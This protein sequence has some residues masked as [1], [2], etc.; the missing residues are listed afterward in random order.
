M[1]GASTRS[2][3]AFFA[4]LRGRVPI[5]EHEL[6][7]VGGYGR[8]R[9]EVSG[10]RGG[11]A[12]AGRDLRVPAHRRRS[13]SSGF[14]NS[15]SESSSANVSFSLP[16]SS[17]RR[18]WFPHVSPDAIDLRAFVGHAITP[19]LDLM[20][21]VQL[22]RYFFSMNPQ[23]DDLRVAGGAV[24]QYLSG[25]AAIAWRLPGSAG[26]R[27]TKADAPRRLIMQRG[28]PWSSTIYVAVPAAA[29]VG[30]CATGVDPEGRAR[31][32]AGG[33]AGTAG[34]ERGQQRKR[35]HGAGGV[36]GQGARSGQGACWPRGLPPLAP[37]DRRASAAAAAAGAREPPEAP[38]S[39]F[40]G[41]AGTGGASG[42][43]LRDQRLGRHRGQQRHSGQHRKRQRPAGERSERYK[44]HQRNRRNAEPSTAA[45]AIRPTRSRCPPAVRASRR[46]SAGPP[47]A[48]A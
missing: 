42:S 29:L 48:I 15:C 45:R 40:G 28:K 8:Q 24:D 20:A 17:K 7:F 12:A 35:R 6:G 32:G 11:P 1:D 10:R 22:T 23:P 47:R 38:D 37:A 30:A 14:P 18:R 21:G 9:F 41:A 5:E 31:P 26:T 36:S 25:W 43:S 39:G 4:G 2:Q 46:H 44:R 27:Q 34:D 3:T 16:V 13:T 33:D 19:E